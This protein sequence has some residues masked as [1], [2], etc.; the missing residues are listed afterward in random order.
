M[1]RQI[2]YPTHIDRKLGPE[3]QKYNTHQPLYVGARWVQYFVCDS[4]YV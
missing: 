1:F 4:I 3:R 2:N